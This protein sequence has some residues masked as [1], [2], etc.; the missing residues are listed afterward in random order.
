MIKPPTFDLTGAFK[1]IGQKLSLLS[2]ATQERTP[3]AG[4]G[5]KLTTGPSGFI[6]DATPGTGDGTGNQKAPRWS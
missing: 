3:L 2:K 4:K 6:I 1:F 5:I